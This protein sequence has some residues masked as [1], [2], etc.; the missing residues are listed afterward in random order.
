MRSRP[1]VKDKIKVFVTLNESLQNKTSATVSV[2]L[3]TLK[4]D[5]RG[6]YSM[7]SCVNDDV[8][9]ELEKYSYFSMYPEV[10]EDYEELMR[11]PKKEKIALKVNSYIPEHIK[12][13]VSKLNG[14]KNFVYY[15]QFHFSTP[16]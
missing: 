7:D 3:F 8:R 1:A 12:K 4:P 11:D 14:R 15:Q 10:V 5:H 2:V 16:L 9:D 13:L 6:K